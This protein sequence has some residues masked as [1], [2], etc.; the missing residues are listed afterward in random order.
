MTYTY[1]V[2]S[3]NTC[4]LSLRLASDNDGLPLPPDWSTTYQDR[5]FECSDSQGFCQLESIRACSTCRVYVAYLVSRQR[6][7][8][9]QVARRSQ[10]TR[11]VQPACRCSKR[12]RGQRET[13]CFVRV[14]KLQRVARREREYRRPRPLDSNNVNHA[15]PFWRYWTIPGNAWILV[16]VG[17]PAMVEVYRFVSSNGSTL[18]K[19]NEL[20]TPVAYR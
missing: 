20:G 18:P 8:I 17:T 11:R 9:K 12:E 15:P 5:C 14:T 7:K 3:S 6:T 19:S 4:E 2:R 10:L 1:L 16:N 13:I